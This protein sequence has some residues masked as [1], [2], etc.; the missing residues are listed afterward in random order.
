[1]TTLGYIDLDVQLPDINVPPNVPPN[2]RSGI[3]IPT[4]PTMGDTE[5]EGMDV[6]DADSPERAEED[7]EFCRQFYSNLEKRLSESR[8]RTPLFRPLFKTKEEALHIIKVLSEWRE[9]FSGKRKRVHH[10]RE[11]YR[12]RAKYEVLPGTGTN[13]LR[14]RKTGLRVAIYEDLFD[15]IR[16]T[17]VGMGHARTARNVLSELKNSWFG[18]TAADVQ[19]V[20]DLCPTCVGNTSRIRASQT[21]LKFMYSPTIGHRAQVDLIDMSSAET[22][23]GY[24]WIVRYRDHHSGKCDVGATR[25]KTAAEVAPVIIRIMASTLVPSILQSDSG[26]EF[27]GETVRVVNR[28]IRGCWKCGQ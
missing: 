19:L 23:D 2:R 26:G 4:L 14:Q 22:E 10:S 9:V 6:G 17:H 21:P 20:I 8:Q 5:S 7:E 27:L 11:E 1:M 28:S 25:E 12:F 24:K 13:V 15:V 16:D 3:V 18:I